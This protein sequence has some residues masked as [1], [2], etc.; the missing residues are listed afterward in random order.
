MHC[1]RNSR[2][3]Q[4]VSNSVQVIIAQYGIPNEQGQILTEQ[5]ALV[6]FDQL[7]QQETMPLDKVGYYIHSSRIEGDRK[8]GAIYATFKFE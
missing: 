1:P 8:S 7:R 3:E 6:L 2:K 5:Q 4:A